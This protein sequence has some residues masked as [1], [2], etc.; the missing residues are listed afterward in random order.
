M[1][2]VFLIGVLVFISLMGFAYAF[3]L[4]LLSGELKSEKRLEVY[5]KTSRTF[6]LEQDVRLRKGK[7]NEVLNDL[8]QAEDYRK[9]PPL[10][11]RLSQAGLAL[12]P[13]QFTIYSAAFGF[14]GFFISYVFFR[15]NLFVGLGLAFFLGFGVPRYILNFLKN[16]RLKNF[17]QELPNAIDI[18]VR[19]VK[20]GLTLN[21]SLS[22]VSREAKEPVA[23]E[24]RLILEL[25]QLG[26]PLSEAVQ[27]LPERMPIA[28][29]NFFAIVVA[30]QSRSGGSLSE[31]LGNL[32]TV[33]RDRKKMRNRITALSQEAKTSAWIIGSL[34]ILLGAFLAYAS[35]Q[36]MD[37]LF[38]TKTGYFMLI[39]CALSMMLGAFVMHKMINFKI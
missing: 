11:V 36:H 30:I 27:K 39:C 14:F 17:T 10:K 9:K 5:G 6:A 37:L 1:D 28:E 13:T 2:D 16:K 19:G 7:V 15:A 21:E 24:F 12:S 32:S 35:P 33:L 34:P 38:R 26:L 23:S 22:I 25:Q 29:S 20:A 31:V 18:L 4:P 8:E 3:I